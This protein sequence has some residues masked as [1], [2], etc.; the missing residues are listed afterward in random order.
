MSTPVLRAL[1]LARLYGHHAP[2]KRI[3]S[4]LD[5]AWWF[6]FLADSCIASAAGAP[7]PDEHPLRRMAATLRRTAWLDW[8]DSRAFLVS[9]L[10]IGD[11]HDVA[12]EHGRFLRGVAL[13]AA[14]VVRAFD[15]DAVE[16]PVRAATWQ[17]NR[18]RR[19]GLTELGE[20]IPPKPGA[21]PCDDY[22]PAGPGAGLESDGAPQCAWCGFP[23]SDHPDGPPSGAQL[24]PDRCPPELGCGCHDEEAHDDAP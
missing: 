23:K 21:T 7:L 4:A 6:H 3:L 20:H 22:D 2:D 24:R 17:E 19:G 16:R 13:A 18:R 8:S 11:T 15:P 5:A 12:Q 9:L 14:A 10:V 1:R